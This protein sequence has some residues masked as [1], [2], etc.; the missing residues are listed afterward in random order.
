LAEKFNNQR[1]KMIGHGNIGAAYLK[2]NKTDT[3]FIYLMD[4][5]VLAE[6]Y[7]DKSKIASYLN[8]I[9]VAYGVQKDYDTAL[10]IFN[11]AK[12]EAEQARDY[13]NV[14]ATLSG[15]GSIYLEMKNYSLSE[16]YLQEA[17]ILSKSIGARNYDM[18][19]QMYLS[20]LSAETG[21]YSDALKY[22]TDATHIKD[23]LFYLTNRSV[24]KSIEDYE[25]A[26]DSIKTKAKNDKIISK[27]KQTTYLVVSISVIAI[28]LLILYYVTR[29]RRLQIEKEK[30][31]V[32]EGKKI[33]KIIS[34]NMHDQIGNGIESIKK[35]CS[36]WND[37]MKAKI[38]HK[39]S[40]PDNVIRESDIMDL[41]LKQLVRANNPDHDNLG[42]LTAEMRT[43]CNDFSK[44][45]RVD[46]ERKIKDGV[47]SIAISP[48]TKND[49]FCVLK[50]A[51]N[52]MAK[53]SRSEKVVVEFTFDANLNF[54][55]VIKDYGVGF[56]TWANTSG[57]GLNNF[58]ERADSI[59]DGQ[60]EIT[61]EMGE[62]TTIKLTGNLT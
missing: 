50:E 9:A 54:T 36:N 26:Q 35:L 15:I 28:C 34:K 38:E 18:Q 60:I 47:I 45:F 16:K 30:A 39:E 44:I 46:I 42:S 3:A 56:D 5:L 17:L 25:D 6:R 14:A 62:G 29:H 22:Y 19:T 8:N 4:A 10:K 48:Q 41:N 11:R 24:N 43:F 23:S 2:Q 37:D 52:N 53:Y 20:R 13:N 33:R 40:F 1:N 27:Q 55:L 61:S 51:L 58:R 49:I 7:G 21:K 57:N 12:S 32:L 59:K 31:L